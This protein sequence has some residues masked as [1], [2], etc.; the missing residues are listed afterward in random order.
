MLYHITTK[1]QTGQPYYAT[2]KNAGCATLND[3]A[4]AM[5]LLRRSAFAKPA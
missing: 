4:K 2:Q 1:R 3:A 5:Q